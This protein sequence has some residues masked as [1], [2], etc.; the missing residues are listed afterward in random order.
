MN[1]PDLIDGT[2]DVGS[3][4]T[5]A[6]D[7]NNYPHIAYYDTTNGDLALV[8]W[9]GFEWQKET[10]DSTGD[11]G[12]W[13]SLDLDSDDNPH[14]SYQDTENVSLKYARWITN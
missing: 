8:R 12:M 5:I 7:S 6:L 10:V 11:V 14:I 4:C 1:D 2:G 3:F 13:C 9:T